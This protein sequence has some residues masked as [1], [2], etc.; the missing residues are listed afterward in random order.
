MPDG[1]GNA[2]T[3]IGASTGALIRVITGPRYQL[4]GPDSIAVAAGRVWVVNVNTLSVTEI[5][6]VTGALIRVIPSLPNVPFAITA[7][8]DGVWL[9]TNVGEKA[10]DGTHPDGSV[11]ELGVTSGRLIRT[12]RQG[13]SRPAAPAARSS[14]TAPTCG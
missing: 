1:N 3:E 7:D 4:N 9:V 11:A 6:S 5:N 14:Q 8:R 12:C 13:R 10:V 2:V